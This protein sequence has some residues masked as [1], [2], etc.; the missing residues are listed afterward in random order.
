MFN[1]ND[2]QCEVTADCKALGPQFSNTLCV[3]RVCVANG[4]ASSGSGGAGQGG[5]GAGGGAGTA[6]SGGGQSECVSSSDCISTHLQQPYLCNAGQCVK[7]TNSDCPVLLP[8]TNTLDLLGS[9]EPIVLGAYANMT[10]VQDP[11]DNQAVINWDLA[12]NEFNS[13]PLGGIAT[14]GVARPLLALVCQS[15]TSD[16]STTMAHLTQ[17]VGAR[18]V[19][20]VL[21]TDR[22]F[23]AFTYTTTS[24][25]T[26]AGGKPIFFLDTGVADL[27]LANLMDNG[28]LWHM[29]GDPRVLAATTVALLQRLEPYVNAQRAAFFQANPSTAEDPSMVPLRVTLVYSDESTSMDQ[30]SVLTTSD[31]NHPETLLTFNGQA[32]T[33]QLPG[34]GDGNFR[35]VQIESSKN[36][37]TPD[38]SAGITDLE[39]FPPHIVIAM[40]TSEFPKSVI[41]PVEN[42]W[43]KTSAPSANMPRP[44]YLMSQFIYNS[45]ELLGDVAQFSSFTPPLASRVVGVN[46][47]EAQDSHSKSLYNAYEGRLQGPYHGTLPLDGTENFYDGAYALMYS[48]AAATFAQDGA[49]GTNVR[50]GLEDR[51]FSVDPTADPVDV[52]PVPIANGSIGKLGAL[53]YAMTLW[54]TM[55]PPNFDR[56][57]GTRISTTSAWCMQKGSAGFSYQADGLIYDPMARV[58]DAPSAG[59]PTCFQG[60]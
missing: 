3:N 49:D 43:Q 30:F 4:S 60:Y 53:K 5:A 35:E 2:T 20:S 58:F 1:L 59:V 16:I 7:L 46:F 32:A 41:P 48:V 27:R 36:F 22:L 31:P 15:V 24:A 25:Y 47:A 28:L 11:H 57:S 37:A 40:A 8:T 56:T 14:K 23:D 55:G 21:P 33:D 45:S 29:L 12:L 51:I 38:V 9:G 19:L 54:G 39:A 17:D 42:S 50:D 34:L 26:N 52:G 6:G 10:N 44:F 13:F 18:A